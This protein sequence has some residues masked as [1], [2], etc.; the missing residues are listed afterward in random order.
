MVSI[1]GGARMRGSLSNPLAK[2]RRHHDERSIQR[3]RDIATLICIADFIIIAFFVIAVVAWHWHVQFGGYSAP[4]IALAALG[5][6]LLLT[7]SSLCV[8][9]R[10]IYQSVATD[11][12]PSSFDD[13][14]FLAKARK[15]L[16][17][18]GN[19]LNLL[20]LCVLI[21]AT[22]GIIRSPFTPVL[23]TMILG[24]QQLGRFRTN[25]KF[26]IWFGILATL[27]LF[28]VEAVHGVRHVP[29][30]PDRLA[31]YILAA[32]FLATAL[33]THS[34]KA[35]NYRALKGF[36]KPTYVELYLDVKGVWRYVFYCPTTRLDLPLD[37]IGAN[38]PLDY[39]QDELQNRLCAIT[40]L[41]NTEVE[42]NWLSSTSSDQVSGNIKYHP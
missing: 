2:F 32:S 25:S 6:V 31:Y 34:D 19:L 20:A 11:A 22:G 18:A 29:P 16:F 42:I 9:A 15:Y 37:A 39:A 21:E 24:A 38:A 1:A 10:A 8:W 23:Y 14:L 3:Q 30:A 35:K 36:P 12:P 17:H 28:A 13:P 5:Y 26:F 7:A 4:L 41:A 27:A 40:S 33:F